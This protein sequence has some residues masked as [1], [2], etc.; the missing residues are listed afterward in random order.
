MK[1]AK[2]LISVLLTVVITFSA[3]ACGKYDRNKVARELD[4][5]T[6]VTVNVWYNDKRYEPYLDNVSKEFN[7][8]NNLVTINPVY[9]E[10][11]NFIETIYDE[12]VKNDNAP[13]IYI[14]SSENCEKAY[15]MGLMLEND[16]YK[17]IYTNDIYGKAAITSCSYDGKLY[18][19][20][21]SFKMPVMVY[22]K[23]YAKEASSFKEIEDINNNYEVTEENAEVTMVYTF[24]PSDMLLN[25]PYVG[26][27]INIGGSTAE[28]SSIVTIDENKVKS[29]VTAFSKLRDVYGIDSS[30]MT[31][32]KC[33]ELFSQNK[34]LYT[35]V[36][37]DRLY[38]LSSS[39]VDYG[40]IP[41]PS[42]E[43]GLESR[44]MS[45][46]TMA[47]VNPYTSN[48]AV[49]K[50][51]ARAISYDYVDEL[52]DT[53]GL[54]CS[55]ANC[56]N[57]IGIENYRALHDIYNDSIVKAKF[58]GVSNIYMRYEIL[59][60]QVWDGTDID[61]AM[62]TFNKEVSGFLTGRPNN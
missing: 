27:Y 21:V 36:S 23:K 40:I 32:D 45:V 47:V 10:S 20:P 39:G 19:Y 53:A 15:L 33:I 22:N 60:H 14:T 17:N 4:I 16:A 34:L 37:S 59:I 52:K 48:I 41:V 30:V 42:L 8:A 13:D 56:A 2:K 3:T 61:T 26:K 24:N 49:S 11:D 12:T 54:S 51:V 28:D 62:E 55:R 25:Y 35:I 31:E 18:G 57:I 9:Y 29:A 1:Q 44:A 6:P 46:T 38:E 50:A 5:E 7:V 43:E 58:V